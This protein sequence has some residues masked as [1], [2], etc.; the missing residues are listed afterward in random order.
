MSNSTRPFYRYGLFQRPLIICIA[1][2]IAALLCS[3][4]QWGQPGNV[5][6]VVALD[7]SS[8]TYNSG[9]GQLGAAGTVSDEAVKAVKSY[10]NLNSQNLKKPNQIK[11][12]GFGGAVVDLTKDFSSDAAALT[13]AIDAAIQPNSPNNVAQQV[14]PS[15]TDVNMAVQKGLTDLSTAKQG[16]KELLVFTDGQAELNPEL[17]ARAL[18][19]QVKLNFLILGDPVQNLQAGAVKTGGSYF[20][21]NAA[22]ELS[23]AFTQRFFPRVNSNLNWVIICLG[24]AWLA[25]MWALVLPLDRLLQKTMGLRF[26]M[27]GRIAIGHGLFWSSATPIIVWNLL[28]ILQLPLFSKC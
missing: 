1:F 5:S 18:A 4:L 6:V 12:L 14:I 7:L 11:V 9:T 8:S 23:S 22:S 17:V 16:C 21:A 24:G 28:K 25:L 3:L 2:L 19:S 26:D 15:A 10:I 20:A 13:G 27:A